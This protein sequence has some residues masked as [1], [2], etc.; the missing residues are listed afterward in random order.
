MWAG[1]GV[2]ASIYGTRQVERQTANDALPYEARTSNVPETGCDVGHLWPVLKTRLPK[3]LSLTSWIP[4][5][6]VLAIVTSLEA[7][8]FKALDIHTHGQSIGDPKA[9]RI[10]ALAFK[11]ALDPAG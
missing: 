2:W 3:E 6:R 4:A 9:H 5:D 11:S 8:T 10:A 7:K 1:V